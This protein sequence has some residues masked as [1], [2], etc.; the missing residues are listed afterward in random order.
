MVHLE[1]AKKEGDYFYYRFGKNLVL[2]EIIVGARCKKSLAFF[3]KLV[4][5]SDDSVT[6]K[7]SRA[8][9]N[10]FTMIQS[11]VKGEIVVQRKDPVIRRKKS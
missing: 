3:E 8:A 5:E 4:E 10:S 1:D 11:K 2:R 6:I 9:F 7:K